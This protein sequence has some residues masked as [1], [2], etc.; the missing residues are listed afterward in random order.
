MVVGCATIEL[1]LQLLDPSSP[2]VE[3]NPHDSKDLAV[4]RT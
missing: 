2:A 4:V 3:L 1:L